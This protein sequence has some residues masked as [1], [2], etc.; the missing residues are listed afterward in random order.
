MYYFRKHH[1]PVAALAAIA[2]LGATISGP[3]VLTSADGVT[4]KLVGADT[5]LLV[6]AVVV[7]AQR[8]VFGL[9]SVTNLSDGYPWGMWIAIDLIIG[10]IP[11]A[12][13]VGAPPQREV[14]RHGAN[15][16]DAAVGEHR[17]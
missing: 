14:I 12:H 6:P 11:Y 13:A 9:G 8:F 2:S 16:A 1:G 3:A 5:V 15:A 17:T 4:W 10:H 7:L